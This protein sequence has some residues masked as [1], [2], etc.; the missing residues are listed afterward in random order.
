MGRLGFGGL[1]HSR[2]LP[3][4]AKLRAMLRELDDMPGVL[5]VFNHPMWD[6]HKVGGELHRREVRR[7]MEECGECLHAVELNGLRDARENREVVRLARE[8]GH[9]LISGGDRHSLEPNA[10]INLTQATCFRD[11]V[12]EI[13]VERKS[14]VLFMEQY[15]KPWEQRI[16]H[17]TLDAVTD[18]PEF[19]DG[20]KR[21][22]DRAFHL[23][24]DGEMKPLSQLW[25]NGKAPLPLRAAIGFVRMARSRTF[26]RGFSLA[27]AGTRDADAEMELL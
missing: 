4:D 14:H 24:R 23:D 21:W 20:W 16:L 3:D 19:I 2:L 1:R 27:F 6:L 22:D 13:R 26:T 18:F 7:F 12:D 9:L 8:T 25:A 5:V 10:N 15:A 17:S 11:F